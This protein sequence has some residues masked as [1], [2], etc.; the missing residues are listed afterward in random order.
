MPSKTFFSSALNLIPLWPKPS[1]SNRRL[2]MCGFSGNFCPF[3]GAIYFFACIN[4]IVHAVLRNE[5]LR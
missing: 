3:A 4:A 2:K 5:T 1:I